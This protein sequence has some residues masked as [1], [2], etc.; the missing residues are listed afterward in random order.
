MGDDEKEGKREEDTK[1]TKSWYEKKLK[2][3]EW[4][5]VNVKRWTIPILI[6]I[7]ILSIVVGGG[8]IGN[9]FGFLFNP[10]VL[11]VILIGVILYFVSK[12]FKSR[13]EQ[14]GYVA[15]GTTSVSV[16]MGKKKNGGIIALLVVLAVIVFLFFPNVLPAK[17]QYYSEKTWEIINDPQGVAIGTR[18]LEDFQK[19]LDEVGRFE[20]AGA[21]QADSVQRG[22]FI[23]DIDTLDKRVF[24]ENEEVV[25]S[26]K[27]EAKKLQKDTYVRFRCGMDDYEGRGEPQIPSIKFLAEFDE[28]VPVTCVFPEGFEIENED[29][30]YEIKRPYLEAVSDYK[31]RS[32]LRVYTLSRERVR[33]F[34]GYHETFKQSNELANLRD[35]YVGEGRIRAEQLVYGPISF[36]MDFSYEKQ[37]LDKGT[38]I[39]FLKL[40]NMLKDSSLFKLEGLKLDLP[41]GFNLD[42]RCEDFDS[43]GNLEQQK[44]DEINKEIAE[45]EE[46][47]DY[48]KDHLKFECVIN[49]D[50]VGNKFVEY[51][52]INA[53]V[54]YLYSAKKY[55]SVKI[56]TNDIDKG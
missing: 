36:D 10:W 24:S 2:K 11:V 28:T 25:F 22:I 53:D 40:N 23:T 49:I 15:P 7:L 20:P 39:L 37:P 13:G 1:K 48:D 26:A 55:A 50:K 16:D 32:R 43:Q 38:H 54:S 3:R 21:K 44:I 41:E 27:V 33:A 35:L 34:G 4:F 31:T 14:R 47:C 46:E 45:C 56:K 8:F 17:V 5:W 51:S 29:K 42:E 12:A 6:L 18:I 52:L 30:K 19:S 9:I